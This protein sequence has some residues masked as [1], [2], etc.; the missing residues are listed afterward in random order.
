MIARDLRADFFILTGDLTDPVVDRAVR[1]GADPAR[2]F[3][4]GNLPES[5]AGTVFEKVLDLA[6]P[7]TL[8][9][10][11]GNIGGLG[12]PIVDYFR[13]RSEETCLPNRSE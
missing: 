1:L 10:G 9:A 13:H 5:E 11:V 7:R 6:G 3:N 12:Q 8:A 2:I 4:L